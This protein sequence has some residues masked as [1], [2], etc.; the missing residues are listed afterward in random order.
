MQFFRANSRQ[1]TTWVS[2]CASTLL[3]SCQSPPVSAPLAQDGFHPV[4]DPQTLAGI[5]H[6]D[7]R[8]PEGWV[9]DD[10]QLKHVGGDPL[11]ANVGNKDF[12][13]TCQWK[14]D[15]A[16]NPR[17]NVVVGSDA[18]ART[19]AQLAGRMLNYAEQ[20][21]NA[22]Q[23]RAAGSWNDVRIQVVGGNV[24]MWL[25]GTQ[26]ASPAPLPD[27]EKHLRFE[28]GSDPVWFQNVLMREVAGDDGLPA[29]TK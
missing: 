15:G 16:T 27:G 4:F 19:E 22:P 24:T 8:A 12:E 23:P 9:A 18:H 17:I 26:S 29:T 5:S 10:N 21:P 2:L 1:R 13:L 11:H 20:L 25:N 6:E 3:L 28:G 14:S 7:G